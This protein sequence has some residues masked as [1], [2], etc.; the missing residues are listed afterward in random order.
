MHEHMK[1]LPKY[2]LE[3]HK[4]PTWTQSKK[5]DG[6]QLRNSKDFAQKLKFPTLS[7]IYPTH[8]NLESKA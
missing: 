2:M 3:C 7:K 8:E 5:W 4:G 1:I 6:T